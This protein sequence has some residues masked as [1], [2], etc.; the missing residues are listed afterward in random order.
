V[1]T[2][3]TLRNILE[4]DK[5]SYWAKVFFDPEY[6]RRLYLDALG[7]KG[8]DLLDLTGEHGGVRTRKI[9]VEPKTEAPAVVTKLIGGDITYV[10]DGRFEP[11]TGIWEFRTTPSKMS[12]KIKIRGKF[13]VEPRGDKKIERVCETEI[14]VGIFGVGGAVESFIEKT[15][16]ESYAKTERFTNAFIKEKG[17]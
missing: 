16:R 2:K 3:F 10:E 17:L 15:T 9:R 7:F 13:W 5:D 11:T 8:F 14:E 4:T 6:N 1:A 12:D